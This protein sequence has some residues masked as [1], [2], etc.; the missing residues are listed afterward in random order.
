MKKILFAII[1]CNR[2][3]YAKNCINS[4]LKFVNLNQIEILVLDN[5]TFEDGWLE[6]L[7]NIMT[8]HKN[9]RLQRW[10]QRSHTELYR[11]MNFAVEYCRKNNIDIVNFLQDD[12][13]FVYSL[14][15]QLKEITELLNSNEN[16]G[17]VRVNFSWGTKIYD[18]TKYPI[19]NI[20]GTNYSV[21][22]S[23]PADNGFTKISVFD[24]TGLFPDNLV[25]H[26]GSRNG[27]GDF[28][29][30]WFSQTS[31]KNGFSQAISLRPNIAQLGM[32]CAIRGGDRVGIYEQ[33]PE[34]FYIREFDYY[35]A[36]TIHRNNAKLNW[37]LNGF[38]VD[39]WG[40]SSNSRYSTN[41]VTPLDIRAR[42]LD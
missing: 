32:S 9:I 14:P 28:G 36:K 20:S 39:A 33:P 2:S 5:C 29:E 18:L 12:Y 4:V 6:Y 3:I 22:P 41:D 38:C 24:K 37:S 7:Q 35:N 8:K 1:T 25:F 26:Y 21:A 15:N 27:K 42:M 10:E 19:I 40:R 30:R 34:E 11:A 13:Q 23:P 17:Q 31:G 16:I